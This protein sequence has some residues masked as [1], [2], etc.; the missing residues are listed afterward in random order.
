M[1]RYS[2]PVTLMLCWV[3]AS[4]GCVEWLRRPWTNVLVSVCHLPSSED[5]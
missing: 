4:G 5:V 1:I 2:E 3:V